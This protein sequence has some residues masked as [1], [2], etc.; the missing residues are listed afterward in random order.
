[1][2]VK[3]HNHIIAIKVFAQN[4]FGLAKRQKLALADWKLIAMSDDW[5][6]TLSVYHRQ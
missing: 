4:L 5:G 3:C 1:M 2:F 6:I